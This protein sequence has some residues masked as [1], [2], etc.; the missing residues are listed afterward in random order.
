MGNN[1]ELLLRLNRPC[2]RDAEHI[3]LLV[4]V[5]FT[6][7]LRVLS[8][9]IGFGLFGLDQVSTPCGL[10]LLVLNIGD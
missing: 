6:S 9:F 5:T 10:S 1:S 4:S 8:L 3:L 7:P 2:F